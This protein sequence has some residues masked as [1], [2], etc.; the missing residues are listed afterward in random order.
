MSEPKKITPSAFWSCDYAL[1]PIFQKLFFLG[2]S[3][4]FHKKKNL[5]FFLKNIPHKRGEWKKLLLLHPPRRWNKRT[6]LGRHDWESYATNHLFFYLKKTI[7]SQQ[8]CLGGGGRGQRRSTTHERP[9]WRHPSPLTPLG[10]L[11]HIDWLLLDRSPPPFQP[12]AQD[13]KDCIFFS[14][15]FSSRI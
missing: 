8:I 4:F 1:K 12:Q 11:T 7:P 5:L 9:L 13:K 15:F 3:F 14:I 2:K 10:R 6:Q